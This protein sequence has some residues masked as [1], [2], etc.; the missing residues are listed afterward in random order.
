MSLADN[1]LRKLDLMERALELR[2][3]GLP[4]E[5]FV[6]VYSDRPEDVERAENRTMATYGVTNREILVAGHVKLNT[7]KMPWLH[8]RGV[9]ITSTSDPRWSQ[10]I[11][12]PE[13]DIPPIVGTKQEIEGFG[14]E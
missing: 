6:A 4:G 13:K 3:A 5:L 10:L 9:G 14:D 7:L 8:G 12:K 2:A 1:L 11:A